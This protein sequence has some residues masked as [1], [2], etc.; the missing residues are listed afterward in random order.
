MGKKSLVLAFALLAAWSQPAA[1]QTDFESGNAWLEKCSAPDPAMRYS[2]LA[3]VMGFTHGMAAQSAGSSTL[4]IYCQ[5]GNV[6]YGHSRDI[7]VKYMQ[8]NP[9]KRHEVGGVLLILSHMKAFPC[10]KGNQ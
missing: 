9:A 4:K 5:P 3:F 2:C 10:P 7:W 6:T 8:D 1:S